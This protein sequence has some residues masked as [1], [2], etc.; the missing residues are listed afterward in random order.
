MESLETREGELKKL[1]LGYLIKLKAGWNIHVEYRVHGGNLINEIITQFRKDKKGT[2]DSITEEFLK[3]RKGEELTETE[4]AQLRSFIEAELE[5]YFAQIEQEAYEQLRNSIQNRYSPSLYQN[6]VQTREIVPDHTQGSGVH[7]LTTNR[8]A[9][10]QFIKI[11]FLEAYGPGR[12]NKYGLTEENLPEINTII[13]K[14]A[15][16]LLVLKIKENK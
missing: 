11:D 13:T 6:G 9:F 8:P 3:N 15:D 10:E 14:E 7:L 5:K 16:K 4:L 2:V 1:F 12:A